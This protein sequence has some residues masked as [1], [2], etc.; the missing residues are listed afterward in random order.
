MAQDVGK[1]RLWGFVHVRIR[2]RNHAVQ[3][4]AMM[5]YIARMASRPEMV[6]RFDIGGLVLS[7]TR[8]RGLVFPYP[9]AARIFLDS[10]TWN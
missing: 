4:V 7:R 8:M 10:S 2:G 9:A 5:H 3:V 1:K 6:T